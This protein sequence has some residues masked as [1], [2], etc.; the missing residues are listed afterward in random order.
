M[1]GFSKHMIALCSNR[2]P[3]HRGILF[4]AAGMERCLRGLVGGKL[5]R[6]AESCAS[7]CL[8][9]LINEADEPPVSVHELFRR[10]RQAN[11]LFVLEHQVLLASCIRY[12]N[13]GN[14]LS[15][16]SPGSI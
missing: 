2:G 3:L 12:H 13:W 16:I 4:E 11:P 10:W 14:G 15:I 9:P 8:L 5:V 1:I 6:V 7:L